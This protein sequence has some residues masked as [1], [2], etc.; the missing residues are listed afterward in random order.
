MKSETLILFLAATLAVNLSPGPSILYVSSVAASNG[1]RAA[2]VSVLG[3]SA[4]IFVHVLA[5]ATGVAALIAASATAFAVLKYLGAMYLAYL[6]MRLWLSARR[7]PPI[8]TLRANGSLWRFFGR[9]FLV[10][11]INPKI[12]LF[13]LAFLPQFVGP[14]EGAL[15]ARTVILGS[16]FIVIGGTVNGC[17]AAV[18]V[19]GV[20]LIGP[21]A[22]TW[23]ER[24]IPGAILIGMGARLALDKP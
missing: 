6:G 12:G 4:G 15:F 13:F 14:D 11:L 7:D 20:A 8:S 23:V 19:K 17:I 2:L 1:L 3:M 9:G 21:R 18:T 16:V 5:A 22:R 24:W 10:D